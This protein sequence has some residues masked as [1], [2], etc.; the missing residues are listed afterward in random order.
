VGRR[1]AGQVRGKPG[2][3]D[4]HLE[5]FGLRVPGALHGRVRR[6]M[7]R[8]HPESAG[9]A[10]FVERLLG[11]EHRVEI[12]GTTGQQEHADRRP[13]VGGG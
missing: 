3:G 5:P 9:N 1:D 10:E 8:D 11:L 2:E 7:C 6:S 12:A 13:P 4:D